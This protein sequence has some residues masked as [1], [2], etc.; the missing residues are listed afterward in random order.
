M[1]LFPP[2]GE[3]ECL[4]EE[5]FSLVVS[6][7]ESIELDF[8]TKARIFR[9][10]CESIWLSNSQLRRIIE[11]HQEPS[12]RKSVFMS[13]VGKL[14]DNREYDMI[15]TCVDSN[16]MMAEL[17]TQI[18]ILNLFNPYHSNGL[19][20]FN[21]KVHEELIVLAIIAELARKEGV[22]GVKEL[23]IDGKRIRDDE[24]PPIVKMFPK[25][26]K[27]GIYIYI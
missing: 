18:G 2:S 11:L 12:W 17:Y 24:I 6:H 27:E 19:Y 23:T 3:C 13:G 21:V 1:Y 9:I 16:E 8:H 10:L 5:E 7:V 20:K 26:P 14:V 25:E 22:D 15:K 4:R